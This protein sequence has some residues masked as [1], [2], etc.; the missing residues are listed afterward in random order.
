MWRRNCN[1]LG[2]VLTRSRLGFDY[3]QRSRRARFLVK[4]EQYVKFKKYNSKQIETKSGVPQGSILGPLLFCI[5]INNLVLASDKVNY[6][7]YADYTTLYFTLQ[8]FPSHNF[9]EI[10]NYELGK[11]PNW[12]NFNKLSLNTT[13]TKSLV[14]H[15]KQRHMDA[16]SLTINNENIEQVSSFSFLGIHLDEN[17][18]WK[19]HID[20][21]TNKLSRV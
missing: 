6:I 14:F 4:R 9:E 12:L 1:N 13:K 16:V 15:T 2:L 7:M 18:T 19:K 5:H 11:I 20:M 21:L 8:D 3:L 10:V 17:L